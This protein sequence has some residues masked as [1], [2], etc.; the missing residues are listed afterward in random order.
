[1]TPYQVGDELQRDAER[2]GRTPP[3]RQT[4]A[5]TIHPFISHLFDGYVLVLS[6]PGVAAVPEAFY[7]KRSMPIPIVVDGR[8]G[9]IVHGS[10][11][12]ETVE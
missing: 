6:K 11:L 5:V 10:E 9:V 3:I 12:P 2:A 7:P 8:Q 4:D 1:M